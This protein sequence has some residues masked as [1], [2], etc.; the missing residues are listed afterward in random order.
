MGEESDES[1]IK[2]ATKN[3]LRDASNLNSEYN[4]PCIKEHKQVHK[5]LN[6]NNYNHDRCR[7]HFENYNS[8]QAFWK[9]VQSDR[10]KKDIRP[11]LPVPED[12]EQIKQAYLEKKKNAN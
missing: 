7:F 11:Y 2:R 12:R 3:R 9:S 4:N 10:R 1:K 8:C 5:C 6:D